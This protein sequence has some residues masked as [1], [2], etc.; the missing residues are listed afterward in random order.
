MPGPTRI[1]KES[2]S[3]ID[4]FACPVQ[5]IHA[6]EPCKLWRLTL[7]DHA[8]MTLEPQGAKRARRD[9][10]MKAADL[11]NLPTAAHAEL[12]Q[13]YAHLELSFGVPPV[14]LCGLLQPIDWI[15]PAC[16]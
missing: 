14:S 11:R 3:H 16:P 2:E 5:Q 4:M 6:Y 1:D 12:R 15:R 10:T 7:S 9:V 13:L 8:R